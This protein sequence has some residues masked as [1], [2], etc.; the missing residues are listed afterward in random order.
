MWIGHECS[1]FIGPIG[2]SA[3]NL[4]TAFDGNFIPSFFLKCRLL[5]RAWLNVNE[6]KSCCVNAD[7]SNLN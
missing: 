6:L 1:K 2:F 4:K 5:T 3:N 7:Q